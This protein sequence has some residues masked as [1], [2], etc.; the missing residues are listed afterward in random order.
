MNIIV[1]FENKKLLLNFKIN[2]LYYSANIIK[3]F[4]L[5]NLTTIYK[6]RFLQMV[7]GIYLRAFGFKVKV[8]FE[9]LLLNILSFFRN[10]IYIFQMI[11]NSVE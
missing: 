3:L 9:K 10:F 4:S 6:K 5:I 2:V 7:I 8:N 11:H 1:R